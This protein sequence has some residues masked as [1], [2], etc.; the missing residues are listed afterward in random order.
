MYGYLGIL[1]CGRVRFE[2]EYLAEMRQKRMNQPS[3]S[4]NPNQTEEKSPYTISP[5]LKSF[6]DW[7]LQVMMTGNLDA[8][9]PAATREYAPRVEELW[10]DNAFQATYSRR[11][12]LSTLPRVANYFLDRAVEICRADYEPSDMDIL[13]ADG[14]TSFNG[15]SSMDFSFSK[16]HH[17]SFTGPVDQSAPLQRYQLIRVHSSSLGEKFKWSN[18]FED[19]DLILYCVAL[20]DYDE[21]YYDNHGFATN[22]M[23]L[24]RNL[25]ENIISHAPFDNKNFLLILNK[26]DLLEEKIEHSPLSECEWFHD[27]APVHSSSGVSALTQSASH[28]IGSKFKKLFDTVNLVKGRKLFVSVVTGLECDSVGEALSY[29]REI[30]IWE[31]EGKSKEFSSASTEEIT[32][33]T[34]SS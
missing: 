20:T 5:R 9:F 22:K 1:L 18:M 11:N 29:G 24:A 26:F 7:L 23:L 16:P 10:R 3:T 19:V 27:F 34:S 28:Y 33:T 17:F 15:L 32:T 30:I 4:A 31:E 13:Y 14:I 21:L 2:E 12:E 8:V 25:F 6:S